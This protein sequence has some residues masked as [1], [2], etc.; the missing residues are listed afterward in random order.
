MHT[1]EEISYYLV[2]NYI[3]DRPPSA[4]A[5]SDRIIAQKV[6]YLS[7]SYGIF[8][9]NFQF[10][11]H[12][13]GPY[14]RV[15]TSMIY[16][17]ENNKNDFLELTKEFKINDLLKSKLDNVK[18]L[19][20]NKPN[21]CSEVYWLEICASLMYLSKKMSTSDADIL[22]ETLLKKKPFLNEHNNSIKK[23]CALMF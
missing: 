2:H 10:F 5:Y 12:K 1:R 3:L 4:C 11:W 15:L 14:S 8:L 7:Q 13:R 22:L 20:N 23:A 21:S 17:I 6:G 18:K 16:N 19:I 9:G